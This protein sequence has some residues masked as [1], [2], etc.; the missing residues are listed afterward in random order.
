MS[1]L[2]KLNAYKQLEK[3]IFEYFDLK[4]FYDSTWIEDKTQMFWCINN[5]RISSKDEKGN[6]YDYS[7][8]KI[9]E[10]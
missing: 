3:E 5:G 8:D 7:V 6:T 4:H 9:Y 10:K 1:L 2:Q